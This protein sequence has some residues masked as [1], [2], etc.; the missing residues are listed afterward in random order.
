MDTV[1]LGDSMARVTAE[2]LVDVGAAGVMLNHDSNP[3]SDDELALAV[4][5]AHGVGLHTIVCAADEEQAL[6]FAALEPTAVLF[7]PPELIGTAGAGDRDWVGSSTTSIH[8]AG[9]GVL[10]M[11]AG[12][13]ATPSIAEDIMA[14]GADGTGSTSG[15]LSADDPAAAAHAFIAAARAGWDTAHA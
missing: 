14:A 6:R 12:G 9:R 1:A 10:A 4:D 7:E 15:V 13:V 8:D 11:H 5:R 3:L 2:S